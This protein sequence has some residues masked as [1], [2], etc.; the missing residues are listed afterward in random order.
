M[1]YATII[2][3]MITAFAAIVAPLFTALLTNRGAFRLK[4]SEWF[5]SEKMTAYREFLLAADQCLSCRSAETLLRLESSSANA[6]LFSS[7]E[8][9]VALSSF[10]RDILSS[11]F[12][13][14]DDTV[15]RCL[16]SS[17]LSVL[18]AMKKDLQQYQR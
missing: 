5:L 17:R 4:S 11:G 12:P 13:E 18:S 6:I 7:K 14:C 8:V 10:G 16:A 1:Q 9:E 15:L 2:V 3:A